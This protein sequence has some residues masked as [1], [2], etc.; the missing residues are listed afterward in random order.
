MRNISSEKAAMA[1]AAFEKPYAMVMAP[2]IASQARNAMGP[3]AVL[4]TRNEDL[5]ARSAVYRSAKS[6]SVWL[7]T[8]WLYCRRSR[9]MRCCGFIL[10]RSQRGLALRPN[11]AHRYP[12]LASG[13]CLMPACAPGRQDLEATTMPVSGQRVG[14]AQRP[15]RRRL[16]PIEVQ[17][18]FSLHRDRTSPLLFVRLR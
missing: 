1:H 11:L 7:A 5:R 16:R 4:P 3:R 8:H 2:P 9:T 6:S 18:G 14:L 13:P 10:I 15:M 12:A 17:A